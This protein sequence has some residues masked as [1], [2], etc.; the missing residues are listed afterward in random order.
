VILQNERCNNK[1][2]G[3]LY[4]GKNDY[5]NGCQPRTNTLK[6]EKGDLFTVCQSI[7]A[8]WREHICQ[9][10]NLHGVRDVGQRYI[11]QNGYCLR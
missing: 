6:D 4:R 2:V 7:L 8:R 9:L 3:D 5:K 1:D 10:F 11:Q